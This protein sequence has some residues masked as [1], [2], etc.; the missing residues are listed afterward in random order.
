[1]K[2]ILTL[3]KIIFLLLFN[4][5]VFFFQEPLILTLLFFLFIF[6]LIPLKYL[7]LE[8]LKIII[9]I[10][11]M[12]ILFQLI[13]NTSIPLDQ[14]FLFGY[15]ASMKIILISLSVFL[16]L[17]FT[18]LFELIQLFNFLPKTWLLLLTLTFY[19]IQSILNETEKIKAAQKSRGLR[20]NSWN[21][22]INLLNLSALIVPLL[23]RI[24]QRAETLSLTIV[25]RGF[26]E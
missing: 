1:M 11:I 15:I 16:F 9:P 17:S 18:S 14:R 22:F 20:I 23:H 10:G 5:L 7:V 2:K 24:F 8:R 6:I 21:I 4:S 19:F 3:V 12:I 25:S 26:E 13:F